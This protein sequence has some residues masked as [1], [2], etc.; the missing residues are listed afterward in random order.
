MKRR[1][2]ILKGAAGCR[3]GFFWKRPLNLENDGRYAFSWPS[4]RTRLPP[5]LTGPSENS[6]VAC[7]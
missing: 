2:V 1:A 4:L 5:P 7:R 3:F 6:A